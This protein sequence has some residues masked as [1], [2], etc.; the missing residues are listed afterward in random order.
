[1]INIHN[2]EI[3]TNSKS[4]FQY[5]YQSALIAAVA[6]G[7]TVMPFAPA[8]SPVQIANAQQPQA[9]ISTN[10]PATT[11]V[12][13]QEEFQTFITNVQSAT[14]G[15]AVR[16]KL[17]LDDPSQASDIDLSYKSSGGSFVD[18]DVGSNGETFFGP[19][20]GFP[21]A[22]ATSTFRL[23]LQATGTYSSTISLVDA[24]S[25]ST[26]Y[27]STDTSIEALCSPDYGNS[28]NTRPVE[29]ADTNE[30]FETIQNAID[31]CDTDN[32]DTIK[33]FSGTYSE[34]VTVDKSLT[35]EGANV[36]LS[37]TSSS[38]GP[39]SE[40]SDRVTIDAN[41]VKVDGF[42][43][44]S[45]SGVGITVSKEGSGKNISIV[46]NDI[47]ISDTIDSGPNPG[48]AEGI[49]ILAADG[50][51][52]AGNHIHD[53]VADGKSPEGVLLDGNQDSDY[54][55]VTIENNKFESIEG[56]PGSFGVGVF[57]TTEG[58]QILSNT[59]RDIT[60][61]EA[62]DSAITYEYTIGLGLDALTKDVDISGNNFRDMASVGSKTVGGQSV[63]HVVAISVNKVEG[64]TADL[65]EFSI[66]QNNFL[67]DNDQIG[68]FYTSSDAP[69]EDL[70][71]EKNYWNTKEGPSGPLGE[72][73]SNGA[74]IG[75]FIDYSPWLCDEA[76]SSA[77]TTDGNCKPDEREG[78]NTLRV[79]KLV[80]DSESTIFDGANTNSDFSITINSATSPD[81]DDGYATTSEFATTTTFTA[82]TSPNNDFFD[83]DDPNGDP[84]VDVQCKTIENLPD[85]NYA[86]GQENINPDSQWEA[87][88]YNDG[89][90]GTPNNLNDFADYSGELFD[91]DPGNDGNRNYKSDG[92]IPLSGSETRA[93]TIKNTYT[94]PAPQEP[95]D[96]GTVRVTKYSCDPGTEVNRSDNDPN[97][98]V[99]ESC[100]PLS[101]VQVGYTYQPEKFGN[102]G[103]WPGTEEGDPLDAT[104]VT[105]SNGE[106]VFDG[107]ETN[108]RYN[109]AE[110]NGEGQAAG[111]NDVLGLFCED[112]NGGGSNNLDYTTLEEAG[113]S[114]ECV[115]YNE[116]TTIS[117]TKFN[118]VN[119]DG[120]Y[121]DEP[122]L[123]GWTIL[124]R[125]LAADPVDT[126]TI[127]PTNANGQDSVNLSSGT[128]YIVEVSGTYGFDDGNSD[129]VADAEYYSEDGFSNYGEWGADNPSEDQRTLDLTIDGQNID[130][131][132]YSNSDHLYKT[133]VEGN[134]A[135]INLSVFERQA[136]HY[137]DNTGS[138]EVE[139][140]EAGYSTTT[141]E[142]GDYTLS[143]PQGE[144]QVL[145]KNQ[146]GWTQTAPVD[147]G[148]Y[149]NVDVTSEPASGVNFGNQEDESDD[150]PGD[151]EESEVLACEPD[152]INHF[153]TGPANATSA[154]LVTMNPNGSQTSS[155]TY[156]DKYFPVLAADENNELYGIRKDDRQLVALQENGNVDEKETVGSA[157]EKPVGMTFAYDGTLYAVNEPSDQLFEIDRS[158]GSV[159]AKTSGSSDLSVVGGDIFVDNEGD[160]IYVKNSGRVYLIEPDT[161]V[162][163]D[164]EEN[165]RAQN[166]GTASFTSAANVNG[167]YYALNKDTDEVVEFTVNKNNTNPDQVVRGDVSQ[168]SEGVA[169]GDAT[170]CPVEPA[171]EEP[172]GSIDGKKIALSPSFNGEIPTPESLL[173]DEFSLDGFFDIGGDA[174]G[175]E[176]SLHP[177]S[178]GGFLET[179]TQSTTTD[180]SGHY[181]FD[182]VPQGRYL[183]C[184]EDR[185][186][187]YEQLVPS[188]N[189]PEN[190]IS[191]FGSCENGTTGYVVNVGDENNGRNVFV[192][193]EERPEQ[194]IDTFGGGGGGGS[195]LDPGGDGFVLGDA[196]STEETEE[197]GDDDGGGDPAP[198]FDELKDALEDLY[199]SLGRS[200]EEATPQ[201]DVAGTQDTASPGLPNTGDGSVPTKS[202]SF[203]IGK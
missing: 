18:L 200:G 102:S 158:D 180:D 169:F 125:S 118:D 190:E 31:D 189:T 110:A 160:I 133:V 182:D 192:N 6:V 49:Q 47:T 116:G 136:S 101:G 14:S 184:E 68:I 154:E 54:E 19:G 99:P 150:E 25:T 122:G 72:S 149:H 137:T 94:E 130:W 10:Q 194:P 153:K 93:L 123:E 7:F 186:D 23:T 74:L 119:G 58:L 12:G 203:V 53:I 167:T 8:L 156:D 30:Y 129:R 33:V 71:A 65:S 164:L 20:N 163:T 139:I 75:D 171:D 15:T 9:D 104:G 66:K 199:E 173:D 159:S 82:P 193:K 50:I 16:G 145:E 67:L 198:A 97:G 55:N 151:G 29:N 105:D 134:D 165:I 56:A 191:P 91:D 135:P 44:N 17:S 166:Q 51:T 112:D 60:T 179:P 176:I 95:Q 79:C 172:T 202:C 73:D 2:L 61:A 39:E 69:S 157:L 152:A 142:N 81:S 128:K 86:Y 127:D 161:G 62:S 132:P 3:M 108:G 35:L 187:E 177:E 148:F 85:G 36:G 141:D 41:D 32:G 175:W 24:D 52:I 181:S 37:G 113:E 45:E 43:I 34:S 57:G 115:I 117:G 147:G 195:A 197:E 126:L 80:V 90:N 120:E 188:G 92:D 77:T 59:F 64:N 121:G 46:N 174:S 96:A 38:R 106:V 48:D 144:Y 78:D 131:G 84:A 143:V 140:Y 98:S 146:E 168:A 109:I 88:Q 76:V 89:S 178:E 170:S 100:E 103:P 27:A 83:V 138:L 40:I 201:P 196:T 1:M 162:V 155:V 111:D 114:D 5:F 11:T 124:A 13:A 185:L 107:L 28:N 4:I 87:A 63:E 70:V 42:K 183:V 22:S 21:L 26:T